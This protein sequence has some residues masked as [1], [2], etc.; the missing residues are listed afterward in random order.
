MCRGGLRM[1]TETFIIVPNVTL[2]NSTKCHSSVLSL[3]AKTQTRVTPTRQMAK[4]H[5]VRSSSG[6]VSPQQSRVS[7]TG[8]DDTPPRDL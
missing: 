3:K 1:L 5:S 8:Q 6:P 4:P 7:E 2:K